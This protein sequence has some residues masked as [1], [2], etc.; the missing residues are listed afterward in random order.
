MI[1]LS[2]G[3]LPRRG[4][5]P[6]AGLW[7]S[8]CQACSPTVPHMFDRGSRIPIDRGRVEAR[9]PI[10]GGGAFR[11]RGWPAP[12][13]APSHIRYPGVGFMECRATPATVRVC[14]PALF[15][16]RK[17]GGDCC[18]S[19]LYTDG[20]VRSDPL[21]ARCPGLPVGRGAVR[22]LVGSPPS[23]AATCPIPMPVKVSALARF[24]I[25]HHHHICLSVD[26][27]RSCPLLDRCCPAR[28]RRMGSDAGMAVFRCRI[29]RHRCCAC[30]A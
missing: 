25:S 29:P 16:Y 13:P 27:D 9:I 14:V 17:A 26:L 12:E 23:D 24:R 4:M 18:R 5:S 1:R 8:R 10:P 28:F 22:G 21:C 11:Y 3:R 6:V 20:C 30:G 15:R 7:G 19:Q 2:R